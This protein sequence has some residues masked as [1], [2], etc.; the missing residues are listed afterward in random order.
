MENR[1]LCV[2]HANCFD[3]FTAAWVVRN[4][5]GAEKVDMHP[6]NYGEPVPSVRDREIVIV[7]FSYPLQELK[8][9]AQIN[10]VLVLDHH[11]TAAEALK[12]LPTVADWAAWNGDLSA[13]FDME[14]SGAGI[15]WDFFSPAH[16]GRGSWT[17]L[18]IAIYG[19]LPR[20]GRAKFTPSCRVMN[21]T[22]TSGIASSN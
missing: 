16:R 8:A 17:M 9:L 20:K 14:R 12:D 22:S 19:A 3:G 5:F 13:V 2:Y 1:I 18:K 15:T 4:Y 21:T 7:D 6:A 10:N 11:K